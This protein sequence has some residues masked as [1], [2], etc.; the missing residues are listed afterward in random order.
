MAGVGADGNDGSLSYR[1]AAHLGDSV[2]V[3]NLAVSGATLAD[4]VRGQIPRLPSDADWA[5]V[6]VSAND[7]T[8][9][10]SPAEF[11]VD[12]RRLF[13]GLRTVRHVVLTTTP[14][15]R[16][17][18]ALPWLLN[19]LFERRATILTSTIERVAAR[20]R[21]VRLADLN[22][23]G[24]LNREQYAADGFHPNSAGYAVWAGIFAR[25]MSKVPADSSSRPTAEGRSGVT[26][27]PP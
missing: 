19:R 20:V 22:R 13:A 3:T 11:E 18:P 27:G 26:S 7:A 23:D 24:T 10:T 8:H 1:I 2:S 6:S 5:V 12:L 14:N 16:T 17:T 15:F 21:S 25:A 9:G 4:V